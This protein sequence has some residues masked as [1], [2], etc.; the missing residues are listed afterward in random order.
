[1]GRN[2]FKFLL[3]NLMFADVATR[4]VDWQQDRFTMIGKWDITIIG[5]LQ[6]VMVHEDY[7]KKLV[8]EASKV[9]VTRSKY[10]YGPSLYKH[11]SSKLVV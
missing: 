7:V 11:Q 3:N 10:K 2:R 9:T 4:E 8:E 1:M 5:N 6:Q